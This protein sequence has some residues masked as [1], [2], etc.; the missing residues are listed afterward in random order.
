MRNLNRCGRRLLK[1]LA[2][3]GLLIFIQAEKMANEP[4]SLKH[5]QAGECFPFITL[6]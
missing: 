5:A 3:G 1:T 2:N 6:T 4:M